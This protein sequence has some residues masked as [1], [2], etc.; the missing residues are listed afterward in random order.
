MI[1][2]KS[3]EIAITV[4]NF[5]LYLCSADEAAEFASSSIPTGYLSGQFNLGRT[6]CVQS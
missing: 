2:K 1:K 4:L 3:D 6:A 5:I